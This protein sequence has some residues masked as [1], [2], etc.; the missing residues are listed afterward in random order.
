VNC[1]A[2]ATDYDGTLAENDKVPAA[3]VAALAS[4]KASGRKLLLVTGRHLPDLKTVF[5]GLDLFDLAVLENGGLLYR[6]ATDTAHPLGTVP[7]AEFVARLREK[8]VDELVVGQTIVA[9]RV[10]HHAAIRGTIEEMALDLEIILNTDALMVLPKGTNKASGLMTAL[11]ELKVSPDDVA[12]IGDAENDVVFLKL[13]GT[14]VAVNNA[15]P[16]VKAIADVVTRG[17]RGEGVA[18]FITSIMAAPPERATA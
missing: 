17:S 1:L 7:S 10:G 2:I 4:F 9:T 13:C 18:E 11:A 5:D 16:E 3:T 14:A 6:P 8:G 12:G 15:L